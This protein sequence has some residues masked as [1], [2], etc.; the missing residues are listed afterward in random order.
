MKKFLEMRGADC[1]SEAMI[2]ALPALWVGLMYDATARQECLRL[3]E[4][5]TVED[6]DAQ[7]RQ[8]CCG[9]Q[10]LSLSR[11]TTAPR[12]CCVLLAALLAL[13]CLSLL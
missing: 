6:M 8:V 7:R 12:I 9:F 13:L 3:I 2:V 5:W 10:P 11:P 4:D 1:G